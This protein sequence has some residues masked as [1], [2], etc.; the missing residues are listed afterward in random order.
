MVAVLIEAIIAIKSTKWVNACLQKYFIYS[1]RFYALCYDYIYLPITPPR[2]SLPLLSLYPSSFKS[3]SSSFSLSTFLFFFI[4]PPSTFML[5][6]YF[7]EWGLFGV[8]SVYQGSYIKENW[9]SSQPLPTLNSSSLCGEISPLSVV[10]PCWDFLWRELAQFLGM[11]HNCHEFLH[12]TV[13]LS[14]E[15]RLT[16][17]ITSGS[18]NLPVS[19]FVLISGP[20][21]EGHEIHVLFEVEHFIVSYSVL[22]DQLGVSVLIVMSCKKRLFWRRLSD[23]L[24]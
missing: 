12:A 4:N 11:Y 1:L 22:R 5:P 18:H 16:S 13:F 8:C 3:S 7:R 9:L 21:R 6:S 14:P 17:S 2:A 10:P 20:V 24:I 15:N 23:I 19:S